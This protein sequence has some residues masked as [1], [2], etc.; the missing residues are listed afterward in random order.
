MPTKHFAEDVLS[1][2]EAQPFKLS[3]MLASNR[4][5]LPLRVEETMLTITSKQNLWDHVWKHSNCK[6]PEQLLADA[7]KAVAAGTLSRA[8]RFGGKAIETAAKLDDVDVD[9][10]VAS[11]WENLLEDASNVGAAT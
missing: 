9:T 3:T 6:D 8:F 2:T 10:D 4:S 11:D 1:A 5:L 7:M